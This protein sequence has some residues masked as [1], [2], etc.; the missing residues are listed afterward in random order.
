[1]NSSVEQGR[2]LRLSKSGR[3]R[4]KEECLSA[5][6]HVNYLRNFARVEFEPA[7]MELEEI[8]MGFDPTLVAA[9]AWALGWL[10]SIECCKESF[11]D[12]PLNSRAPF[13]VWNSLRAAPK[14]L[15]VS[16]HYI[17][18]GGFIN[19][20]KD[21]GRTHLLW[22]RLRSDSAPAILAFA[23]L[24]NVLAGGRHWRRREIGT[25]PQSF[26][27]A[28]SL[29][30]LCLGK[31]NEPVKAVS[32]GLPRPILKRKDGQLC[33]AGDWIGVQEN[34]QRVNADQVEAILFPELETSSEERLLSFHAQEMPPQGVV[35]RLSDSP[36]PLMLCLYSSAMGAHVD[37]I[38]EH[39][40][41]WLAS[42]VPE[43]DTEKR[44]ELLLCLREAALNADQHG[45]QGRRGQRFLLAAQKV[46]AE[47]MVR[48][49]ISDPGQG[50]SYNFNSNEARR[51]Q[52]MGKHLGLRLIH[53]IA[54]RVKIS[55]SGSTIEFDY[56]Y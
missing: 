42:H 26:K 1:M 13:D 56:R 27:D 4:G 44:A 33:H 16:P 17:N 41:T 24:Q 55:Q 3:R 54:T 52:M 38:Q 9:P 36:S 12:V 21:E 29:G 18:D 8:G 45:C 15:S 34:S 28:L 25:L 20:W 10:K 53:G 30:Y 11:W 6:P 40:S 7:V 19:C 43:I 31:G 47:R 2:I 22:G 23:W 5:V 14:G 35:W 51:D 50:H 32:M 46:E 39:W 48:V 49:R 37:E